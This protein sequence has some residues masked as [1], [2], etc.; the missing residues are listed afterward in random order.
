MLILQKY[1]SDPIYVQN[2]V[3]TMINFMSSLCFYVSVFLGMRLFWHQ[4]WTSRLAFEK[5]TRDWAI[6]T[7]RGIMLL[8]NWIDGWEVRLK[9]ETETRTIKDN[10]GTITHYIYAH[11]LGIRRIQHRNRKSCIQIL[12]TACKQLNGRATSTGHKFNL[13]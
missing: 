9:W 4:I 2:W 1:S 5:C 12:S 6:H 13:N 8:P 3:G 11:S 10:M 7:K